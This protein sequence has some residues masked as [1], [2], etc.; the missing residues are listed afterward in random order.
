MTSLGDKVSLSGML[1]SHCIILSSSKSLINRV[2]V[3]SSK[4]SRH[5]TPHA[6]L[7]FVYQCL[8]SLLL[9]FST[10]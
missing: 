1:T 6:Y 7:L 9:L 4:T 8:P 2:A 10:G 5:F 3:F